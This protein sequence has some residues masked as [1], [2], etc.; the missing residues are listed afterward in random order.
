MR[1]QISSA[2]LLMVASANLF[3]MA[4]LPPGTLWMDVGF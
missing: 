2:G 4:M 1:A 3:S